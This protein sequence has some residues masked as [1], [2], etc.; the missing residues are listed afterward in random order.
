MR[1]HEDG[2]ETLKIPRLTVNFTQ[3]YD[4]VIWHRNICQTLMESAVANN[5]VLWRVQNTN[6]DVLKDS[7][8]IQKYFGEF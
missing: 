8:W 1:L 2:R 3:Q 6:F 4:N 7:Y 5:A